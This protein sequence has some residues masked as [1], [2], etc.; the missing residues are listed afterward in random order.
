LNPVCSKKKHFR[1][2]YPVPTSRSLG[3]GLAFHGTLMFTFGNFKK[4]E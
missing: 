2:D 1:I 4:I 3:K